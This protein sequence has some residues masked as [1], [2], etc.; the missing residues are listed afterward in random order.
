MK[1]LEEAALVG[2]A[3]QP[4]RAQVALGG[5]LPVDTLVTELGDA[6]AIER[7]VLLAAALHDAYARAGRMPRSDVDVVPPASAETSP[8]CNPPVTALIADLLDIRPRVLLAEAL[9]RLERAGLIVTPA[10]LPGL[11][12]TRDPLLATVLPR[13]MGE[14]GR[15]L[16]A[17]TGGDEWLIDDA[18]DPAE[19][20]RL[21]E[22]GPFPRRLAVLR[23]RRQVAPAEGCEW[24]AESWATE[25]AEQRV[26]F[27]G[28][29]G[30]TLEASDAAFLEQALDDR[31]ANVRA[32]AARL[33]ARLPHS[34]AA[35]RFAERADELLT[36][37]SPSSHGIRAR[38]QKAIGLSSVG[39]L[40]VHSPEQWDPSWERDGIAA[41]PPK[42]VGERA[43][44]LTEALAL[45]APERWTRRFETDA[46]TLVGAAVKTDWAI[47]VLQGWS[48]AA[49]AVGDHAWA[50]ALW[51]AWLDEPALDD[52]KLGHAPAYQERLARG[53]LM[54]TLHRAMS[55]DDA[56]SRALALMRR[57]TTELPFGLSVIVDMVP[58]PWG[59]EYSRR[60]L[61]ELAPLRAVA[62]A[63]S[64][65]AP[66]TWF[67]SLEPIAMRLA[68]A[69]FI[70][71]LALEQ[72]ISSLDALP[73][74]YR[75]GL[76]EFREIVRLRQ[77]IHEEIPGEQLRR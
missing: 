7:R 61:A 40:T 34:D 22:E 41:K 47:P 43:H 57:A 44:W 48:L 70:D 36:Y 31:S 16:V 21:W 42:G 67:E 69:S 19:A 46:R 1:A 56:E 72:R 20:R 9:G 4:D 63:T 64:Q 39:T 59:V 75:R 37:Q 30:E 38:M 65:W 5:D 62:A 76:D 27:L 6:S 26:Q 8:V 49:S 66:G 14:R 13:V 60:F 58:A 11:L 25:H 18:P 52:P 55:P 17:L 50:A 77:R 28:V 33:L 68:P 71:A 45:V 73:P 24:I 74:A 10:L 54:I 2:T 53:R 12:D 35:H 3:R 15:W 23:A 29:L 32:A 51:D